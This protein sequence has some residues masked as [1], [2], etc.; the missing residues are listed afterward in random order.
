MIQDTL[1]EW[2]PFAVREPSSPAEPERPVEPA[3]APAGTAWREDGLA[4]EF[5]AAGNLTVPGQGTR[6]A[7]C[8]DYLPLK[9]CPSCGEPHAFERTCGNR[10]CPSCSTVW[11]GE[12]AEKGTVRLTAAREVE[13]DGYRRRLAHIVVSAPE[14]ALGTITEYEKGKRRAYQ[15]AQEHGV[16]GGVVI[17]HAYRVTDEAKR[18]FG[19]LKDAGEVDCGLWRWILTEREGDWRSAVYFSPHYH[20]VGLVEDLAESSPESDGGWVVSRIRSLERHHLTKLKPYEDV[21]G[22]LYYLLSHAT[23]DPEASQHALRWFGTLA[24]NQFNPESLADWKVSVIRRLAR[25]ARDERLDEAYEHRCDEEECQ[26]VLAPITEAA[27]HLQRPEW[28]EEIGR[29]KERRLVAA[30]KWFYGEVIPPPGRQHPRSRAQ[31]DVVLDE[32]VGHREP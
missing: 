2:K 30:S 14:G 6:P 27:A 19:A 8:G 3:D 18:L 11:M 24:Y 20:I 5:L 12:H 26:G 29:E 25:N 10:S 31:A 32:L 21:Y 23:Y 28:C 17:G 7:D 1:G 13:P 16:R 9:Y 15:L 4:Q 22:L